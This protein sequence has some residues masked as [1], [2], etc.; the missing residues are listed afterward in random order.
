MK[1]GNIERGWL[2]V[3]TQPLNRSYAKYLGKPD[4]EGILIS[5]IIEGSP[6][7]KAG[8]MP[9]DVLL[10]YGN[11]KLSAEKEDDLNKLSLLISQSPAGTDKVVTIYRDGETK[12]LN[13]EI[14]EQP[15]VKADEFETGLGFTIKEIT[16]DMY[17][18][19]LLETKDGVY[20]SFV[21]VGTIA[22]K[23]FL[24]EG[25]V[26]TEVNHHPTPDFKT[27]KA[28]INQA[29]NDNYIL[30]SLLRGK[31]H[32]LA[33]LDK[34]SVPAIDTTYKDKTEQ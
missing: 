8:L 7:A 9:G 14:G 19:L 24:Y 27:F 12:K 22:D 5:D 16:D 21:D 4:M 34:S 25:D 1:T 6:A 28:A 3:V 29:S 17:R 15:K 18:S 10:D 26:I 31:E 2:G 23:G 20:V 30:L 33:L 13:I 11:E 32:K